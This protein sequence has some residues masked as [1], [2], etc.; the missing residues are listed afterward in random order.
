MKTKSR[1]ILSIVLLPFVVAASVGSL[2]ALV[3]CTTEGHQTAVEV[4]HPA[5]AGCDSG[6]SSAPGIS[7]CCGR[8]EGPARHPEGMV[9]NS[10]GPESRS[11]GLEDKIGHDHG[12]CRDVPLRLNQG[13]VKDRRTIV[14]DLQVE[15]FVLEDVE[16]VSSE[17][18]VR[19]PG[20]CSSLRHLKSVVLLV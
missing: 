3:L 1:Q 10:E 20:H 17:H 11:A 16:R 19:L 5:R 4:A 6:G 2:D 13:H 8:L 7:K 15:S 14:V 18:I 12:L 9:S